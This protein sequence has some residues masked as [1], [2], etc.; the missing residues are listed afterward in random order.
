M[1]YDYLLSERKSSEFSQEVLL[2]GGLTEV[3]GSDFYLKIPVD[4]S[5]SGSAQ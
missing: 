4:V 2:V 3:A 1:Y 5:S